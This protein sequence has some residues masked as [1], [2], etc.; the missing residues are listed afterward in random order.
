MDLPKVEVP[1]ELRVS[2]N[3][4]RITLFPNESSS[5]Y[6]LYLTEEDGKM[7]CYDSGNASLLS[8]P[9]LNFGSLLFDEDGS[10]KEALGLPDIIGSQPEAASLVTFANEASLE[11]TD[12]A[13]IVHIDGS[14]ISKLLASMNKQVDGDLQ[15]TLGDL[16]DGSKVSIVY[17]KDR[18]PQT[19]KFED[20][21]I[22]TDIDAGF[23]GTV[24]V[25]VD[26]TGE[27]T[28]ERFGEVSADETEVPQGATKR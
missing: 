1:F 26:V 6:D 16:L 8:A 10:M 24:N 27:M 20:G 17:G 11:R 14:S 13:D 2:N 15:G 23:F 21:D 28:F 12:D 3:R 9:V 19:A 22:T 25:K 18:I 7:A 4:T 5:V